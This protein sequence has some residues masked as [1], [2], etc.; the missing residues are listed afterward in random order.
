M[1]LYPLL[2]FMAGSIVK[3]IHRHLIVSVIISLALVTVLELLVYQFNYVI[4]HTTLQMM[5]FM[6]YRLVSTLF[7]NLLFVALLVWI[8]SYLTNGRVFSEDT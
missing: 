4:G 8:F 3:V 6:L 5:D 1:V 7:A 2:T